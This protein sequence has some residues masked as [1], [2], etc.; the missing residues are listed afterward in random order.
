MILS[1][2]IGGT[3][4]KY[5]MINGQG[6][7]IKLNITETEAHLGG[8][9]IV[10]KVCSIVKGVVENELIEGIALS[11]AGM[12]NPNTGE[13]IYANN[14]IPNY[15]GINWKEIIENQF[16]I[17]CAVENDSN[18]AGLAEAVCGAGKTFSHVLCVTVG[19]GIGSSLVINKKIY[20]GSN[21]QA[22]EIGYLNMDDTVFEKKAST[23]A[24]VDQLKSKNTCQSNLDGKTILKDAQNGNQTYL[25]AVDNMLGHLANGLSHVI[26]TVNPDV[27]ILGGGIME[28][29][30]FLLPKLEKKLKEV[31]IEPVF[32]NLVICTAEFGNSAGVVGAYENLMQRE[33]YIG[34]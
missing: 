20:H 6:E 34:N 24:L 23:S 22:M 17:P 14:N 15:I 31:L 25:L 27:L 9:H 8:R 4:I 28:Q 32:S 1:F 21:N 18:C 26:Y 2:D 3:T 11:T 29:R 19:T 10:S 5:A 33:F 7:I 12:V 16:N 13:I 30:M